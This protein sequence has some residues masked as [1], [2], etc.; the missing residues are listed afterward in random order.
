MVE[1]P[2]GTLRV[3]MPADLAT[4]HLAP[5]IADFAKMYPLIA[6]EFDLP[7]RQVD[8][9]TEPIDL[10]IR[11]GP[12]PM[13]PLTLV[14]RPI[15]VLPRYL[16]ASLEYLKS[17]APLTHPSDLARHVVCIVEGA[18]RSWEV[19]RTFYRGDES[20]DMMIGTRFA[21]NSVTLIRGLV[22]LAVL[23]D[24]LARDDVTLGRL[25]RVLPDWSHAPAQV[26]ALTETR[27][28]PARTR[29]FIDFLSS[30]CA[31]HRAR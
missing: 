3:S 22:G 26:Y 27:L 24:M 4:D 12:P 1:R 7:P 2:T 19:A 30:G 10:A 14:A 18:T 28:L 25:V 13:A 17:A 11:I 8:L 20:V 23:N 6:F 5:I 21:M 29:L 9:Q 15:A 16:Y 31:N